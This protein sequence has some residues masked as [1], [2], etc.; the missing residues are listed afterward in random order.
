MQ[1]APPAQLLMPEAITYLANEILLTINLLKKTT[2][3][4]ELP[5]KSFSV[6]RSSPIWQKLRSILCSSHHRC[7]LTIQI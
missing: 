5:F 7:Q 1:L 6:S 3:S 4:K 2:G